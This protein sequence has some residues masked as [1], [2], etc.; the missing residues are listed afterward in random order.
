MA[1]EYYIGLWGGGGGAPFEDKITDGS[2]IAIIGLSHGSWIDAL[3]LAIERSGGKVE[4]L[5]RHGGTG[6]K[7]DQIVIDPGDWITEV[8]GTYGSYV[9]QLTLR[10]QKGQ[11]YT[12]GGD[13]GSTP[14]SYTIPKGFELIGFYGRSWTYLDSIGVIIREL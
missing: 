14:F 8:S 11:V 1:L 12:Y 9:T 5:P 10:T 4:T 2:R 3:T 7:M 13:D 6:G